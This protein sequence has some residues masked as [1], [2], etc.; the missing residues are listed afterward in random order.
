[1][2]SANQNKCKIL[3]KC[4]SATSNIRH[5]VSLHSR[6][7]WNRFWHG[8]HACNA[9]QKPHSLCNVMLCYLYLSHYVICMSIHIAPAAHVMLRCVV[10]LVIVTLLSSGAYVCCVWW[11][12][13]VVIIV[14]FCVLNCHIIWFDVMLWWL[15]LWSL[16]C[17][18]FKIV[19]LCNLMLVWCCL[20]YVMLCCIM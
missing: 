18:V 14:V 19:T 4:N 17:L 1:M 9:V 2:C 13:W 11:V 8:L 20:C 12:C 5:H 3:H 10:L 15:A 6:I 7:L 16:L